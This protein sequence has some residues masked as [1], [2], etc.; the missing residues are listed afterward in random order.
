MH[1]TLDLGEN[2]KI[3]SKEGKVKAKSQDVWFELKGC[4]TD[5]SGDEDLLEYVLLELKSLRGKIQEKSKK[6]PTNSKSDVAERL[7]GVKPA[8][9]ITVHPPHQSKNKGSRKRM[10]SSLEKS[11]DGRKI[12][13]RICKICGVPAL[14]DSRNCPL[15]GNQFTSMS[16]V[17]ALTYNFSS[18]IEYA[19][20]PMVLWSSADRIPLPW[21]ANSCFFPDFSV[22]IW[23]L[24]YLPSSNR[25]RGHSSMLG[26]LTSSRLSENV[27]S[28]DSLPLAF[29]EKHAA[30]I[31]PD[32]NFINKEYDITALPGGFKTYK[33]NLFRLVWRTVFVVITTVIPM[34]MP[35]FDTVSGIL[36]AFGFWPLTVY[37]PVEMYIVQK[38]IPKWSRKWICLQIISV[39]C[40]I[41]S[42]T[43][44][45]G[46]FAGL[47]TNL[48]DYRPFQPN[49]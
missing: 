12:P 15:K 18:S 38:K 10:L 49:Y 24:P 27:S 6:K 42:I 25:I 45:A 8:D 2:S 11:L 16:Q 30:R 33:L 5:V 35:F 19:Q 40:L 31:F 21:F 48:K 4:V 34:L 39:A 13:T 37:F 23:A 20:N 26:C 32:S 3:G 36:G 14:H 46:A 1:S 29:V 44:A 43:A 22:E 7:I 28:F 17:G 47:V 41:I 9:V